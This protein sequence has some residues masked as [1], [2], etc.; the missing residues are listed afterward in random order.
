MVTYEE[1][2]KPRPSSRI[3]C[4]IGDGGWCHLVQPAHL[5]CLHLLIQQRL[6]IVLTSAFH[7]KNRRPRKLVSLYQDHKACFS[8]TTEDINPVQ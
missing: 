5:L 2:R 3:S 4:V 6:Y 7:M 1:K 8:I